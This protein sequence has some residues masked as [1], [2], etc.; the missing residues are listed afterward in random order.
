MAIAFFDVDKT[1]LAVNSSSGWLKREV[2]SGHLGYWDALRAS[3][4]VVLYGLGFPGIEDTIVELTK[5]QRGIR[6]SS[7]V[8]RSERFWSEEVR[9]LIRAGA[10]AVIEQHRASGD[11]IVLLTTAPSYLTACVAEELG[12]TDYLC[13]RLEVE[14]GVFTG[15]MRQPLCFGTGKVAH[16]T[17]YAKRAGESLADCTFYTD[18]YSDLPML[19]AVGAP[20]AVHPDRR[21]RRIAEQRGWRIEEWP[22]A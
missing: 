9:F 8:E 5:K 2:Q 20:V 12:A 21:L 16:A 19:V 15:R 10:R 1:I 14:D 7:V 13:N 17:E 22:N 4:S 3:F 11:K 6:E 18:S